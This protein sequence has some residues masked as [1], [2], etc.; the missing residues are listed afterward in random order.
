MRCAAFDEAAQPRRCVVVELLVGRVL[1]PQIG[2][3]SLMKLHVR[4][5]TGAFVR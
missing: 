2:V 1:A 5:R 3:T 4:R